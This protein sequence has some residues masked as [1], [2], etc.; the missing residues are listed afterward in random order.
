MSIQ[1]PVST[2]QVLNNTKLKTRTLWF[3]GDTSYPSDNI[4]TTFA[5]DNPSTFVDEMT[6]D[7][8]QY[9]KLVSDDKQIK[10]KQSIR[11]LKFGWTIPEQYLEMDLRSYLIDKLSTEIEHNKWQDGELE[12]SKRAVRV[13]KELKLFEQHELLDVLRVLIYVINTLN[14][15]SVVWGVGRGSS[16]SSYV[17]YL[18][19]VHDVDSVEY[20]LDIEDFLH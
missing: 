8:E 14:S 1:A 2:P 10:V 15:N 16:V 12:I 3:D 6:K 19:G 17:L 11:P 7:I 4:H 20:E 9:N 18:I 5:F 13:A